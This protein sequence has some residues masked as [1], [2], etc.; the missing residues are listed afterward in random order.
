MWSSPCFVES[1]TCPWFHGVMWVDS[2]ATPCS[3]R[4]SYSKGVS[5]PSALWRRWRLWKISPGMQ[6]DAA[7]RVAD[8]FGEAPDDPSDSDL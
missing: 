1:L 2:H 4:F 8:L 6:S 7:S 3:C 5:M